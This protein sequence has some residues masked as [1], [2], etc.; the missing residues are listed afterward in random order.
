MVLNSLGKISQDRHSFRAAAGD[1]IDGLKR[2]DFWATLGLFDLKRKYRRSM[3]GPVWTTIS[4]GIFIAVLGSLYTR[5]FNTEPTQY[6]PHLTLGMIVWHFIT[7]NIMEG[8]RVFQEGRGYILESRIP[9]GVFVA[10]LIWR[11][12]ILLGYEMLVFVV[13]LLIYGIDLWPTVSISLLGLVFLVLTA[14]WTIILVGIV[15]TRFSDIAEIISVVIR[16]AFFATPVL[17]MPQA[18]GIRS[19]YVQWNPFYHYIEMLRGPLTG[20]VPSTTSFVVVVTITLMGWVVAFP[21]FAKFRHRIP[22]WL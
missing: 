18:V 11:N 15:A 16:I 3:I 9:Y 20:V 6:I 13:V 2:W 14:G 19:A 8:C 1:L 22:Y 17:W 12:L 21:L 5:I 7:R 10:R 4:L